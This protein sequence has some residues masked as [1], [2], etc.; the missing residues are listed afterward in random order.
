MGAWV[1]ETENVGVVDTGVWE[2]GMW[3]VRG[4]DNMRRLMHQRI[5]EGGTVVPGC[6]HSHARLCCSDMC[7]VWISGVLGVCRLVLGALEAGPRV[8]CPL[9]LLELRLPALWESVG[10][11]CSSG[12][13]QMVVDLSP[14]NGGGG[15]G[16][17]H[18]PEGLEGGS[19]SPWALEKNKVE[20][21]A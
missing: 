1:T 19:A 21:G 2:G 20:R 16:H 11:R 5:A 18:L 7:S 9:V 17:C 10:L 4:G 13:Q 15:A 3:G 8:W 14:H 12:A 6:S